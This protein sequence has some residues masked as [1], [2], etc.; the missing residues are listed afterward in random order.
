MGRAVR[1]PPVAPRLR[2]RRPSPPEST[3]TR[4]QDVVSDVCGIVPRVEL[5]RMRAPHLR[6]VRGYWAQVEHA[7]L[8]SHAFFHDQRSAQAEV[9]RESAEGRNGARS[10]YEPTRAYVRAVGEALE[11]YACGMYDGTDWLTA[12]CD[13][14]GNDAL[15]PHSVQLPDAREYDA[16]DGFSPLPRDAPIRWLWGY[17]LLDMAPRLVPA[18][19]A[20]VMLNTL[21]NEPIFYPTTSTGWALHLTR[22]EAILTGLREVI[23]RD[24]FF[25]HWLARI[26]TRVL[27]DVNDEVVTAFLAEMQEAGAQAHIHVTSTDIDVAAFACYITHDDPAMPAFMMNTAAHADP[28]RGL[29][30]LVEEASMMHMDLVDLKR[31]GRA[32][33]PES[34]GV[35]TMAE[36]ANLYLDHAHREAVDWLLEARGRVSFHD[37]PRP[38]DAALATPLGQ[39]EWLVDRLQRAGLETYYIDTTPADLASVG[40]HAAKVLVPG[41]VR[42][43]YGA[44]VRLLACPRLYEAPVRMGVR[45]QPLVRDDINP[46]PHPYA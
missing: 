29:H 9:W 35:A 21:P 27:D 23:E 6:R 17:R 4:L 5:M 43:E 13:E 44:G 12:S 31:S 33:V 36:H 7:T 22:E 2:H 37:L 25:L 32:T 24:A 39:V 20:Y 42:H 15:D 28:T 11:R 16:L 46:D 26:P 18:Q 1:P 14:L 3:F 10:A 34:G 40:F 19:L 30:Q 41:S 38:D 45:S 8:L